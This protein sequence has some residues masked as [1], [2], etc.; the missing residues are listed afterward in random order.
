MAELGQQEQPAINPFLNIAI[1]IRSQVWWL[2]IWQMDT[3]VSG[4]QK[5]SQLYDSDSKARM[6]YSETLYQCLLQ[7][8]EPGALLRA[9]CR[10]PLENDLL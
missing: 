2:S 8:Q 5:H 7:R 4:V 1:E 9:L 10:S 6:G 3:A